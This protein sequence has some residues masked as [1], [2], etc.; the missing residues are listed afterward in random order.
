[1]A[2]DYIGV[3]VVFGRMVLDCSTLPRWHREA[4]DPQAWQP[5]FPVSQFL[6][7]PYRIK[8]GQHIELS[9]MLLAPS[10]QGH[11]ALP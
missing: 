7:D 8:L 5:E 1:M 11:E 9:F 3:G 4:F 2:V 6:L 10:R